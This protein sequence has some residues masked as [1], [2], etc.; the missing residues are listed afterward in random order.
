MTDQK[1]ITLGGEAFPVPR[2][3]LGRLKRVLPAVTAVSKALAAFGSN[4]LEVELTEADYDHAVV[5]IG[6]A[7]G[8]TR[9]EVEAIPADLSE[10]LEAIN[11]IAD[12]AGLVAKGGAPGEPQPGATPATALT[13]STGSSL[14]S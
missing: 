12:V 2:I 13:P 9:A 10:L 11:V 14:T 5:A 4:P 6:E 8:K 7:L 3:P 1:T